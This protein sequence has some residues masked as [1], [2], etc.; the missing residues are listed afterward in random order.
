[1]YGMTSANDEIKQKHSY[2]KT[3][4]KKII[5]AVILNV[6]FYELCR[7]SFHVLTLYHSAD[8]NVLVHCSVGK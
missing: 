5:C 7:V 8:G 3:K 6:A 1:M 4:T 2:K